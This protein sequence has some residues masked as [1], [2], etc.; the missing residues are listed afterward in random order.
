MFDDEGLYNRYNKR[1]TEAGL[2]HL[3][4]ESQGELFHLSS[5]AILAELFRLI[6]HNQSQ[7]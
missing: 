5:V 7:I 2:I 6:L 4:S 1:V 3:W